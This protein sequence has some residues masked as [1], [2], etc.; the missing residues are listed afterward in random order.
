MKSPTIL[1]L[2]LCTV[3]LLTS[4]TA[5]ADSTAPLNPRAKR[6]QE[7]VENTEQE[8]STEPTGQET[9]TETTEL[10]NNRVHQSDGESTEEHHHLGKGYIYARGEHPPFTL[11][12]PQPLG[13]GG[14][15]LFG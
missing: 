2:F 3:I 11:G 6:E 12:G 14:P 7:N 5:V 1:L 4:C 8:N 9:S 15:V 13:L 10:K